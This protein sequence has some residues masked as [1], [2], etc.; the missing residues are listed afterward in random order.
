MEYIQEH[1][2]LVNYFHVPFMSQTRFAELTGY[3]KGI[4]EGWVNRGYIPTIKVGKH[5]AIN[6]IALTQECLDQLPK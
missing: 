4:I 3:S 1:Q 6:L 5:T 2:P